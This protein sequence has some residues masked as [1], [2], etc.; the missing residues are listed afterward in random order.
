VLFDTL[1]AAELLDT[2]ADL[3]LHRLFHQDGAQVLGGK[4]LRFGCSCSRERVTGM[5]ETLGEAEARAAAEA[6]AGSVDVHC[7]FCGQTY[8]FDGA[9]LDALFAAPT[10]SE[11][12]PP[13]RL[14]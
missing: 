8:R 3:L 6:N 4:P 2:P 7:E 11:H 12:G 14:Q 1:G 10:G 5:L 9:D 13:D